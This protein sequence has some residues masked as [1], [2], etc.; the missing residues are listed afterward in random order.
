MLEAARAAAGVPLE[1]IEA[2]AHDL[3]VAGE[4]ALRITV[5]GAL[6]NVG[7]TMA[8]ITL[9]RSLGKESPWSI[10]RWARPTF[11]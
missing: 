2:L 1:A 6:R 8:A 5:I 10:W 7:T 11:R 3:A 4:G 9:A